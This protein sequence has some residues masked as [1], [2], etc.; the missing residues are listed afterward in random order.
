MRNEKFYSTTTASEV[1]RVQKR[2][3][4][5]LYDEGRE[6]YLL[7]SNIRFDNMWILPFPA[8]KKNNSE[9]FDKLC[10]HYKFYNCDNF[11]GKFIKFYVEC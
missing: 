8:K 10:S 5:K 3:A 4:Q 9:S 7:P 2:T 6:I 11:C 1:C